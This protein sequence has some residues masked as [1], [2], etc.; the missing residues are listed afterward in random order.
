MNVSH[1]LGTAMALQGASYR[2]GGS[3]PAAGFDCSGLVQYVFL[4]HAVLLPRT[5]AD[6]FRSGQRVERDRVAPGDLIF[7]ATTAAGATH[8]GIVLDHERFIHAPD[9]GAVVRID[10][11]DSPYWRARETGIRRVALPARNP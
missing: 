5:A 2:L 6:Q 8:V 1:L 9:T 11:F 10:R 4:Q 3:T 7:F